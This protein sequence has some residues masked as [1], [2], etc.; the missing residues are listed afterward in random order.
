MAH[1]S[2][3][4]YTFTDTTDQW[5]STTETTRAE[6]ISQCLQYGLYLM[7]ANCHCCFCLYCQNCIIRYMKSDGSEGQNSH[8]RSKR[9][10]DASICRISK[11]NGVISAIE[12]IIEVMSKCFLCSHRLNSRHHFCC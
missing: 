9:S 2:N 10:Y 3:E 4:R 11:L 1:I 7:L 5:N 6:E 12:V 8:C